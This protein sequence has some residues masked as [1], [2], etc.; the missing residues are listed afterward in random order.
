MGPC[1]PSS[2]RH[3][4]LLLCLNK[5]NI[6]DWVIRVSVSSN[7]ACDLRWSLGASFAGGTYCSHRTEHPWAIENPHT[8]KWFRQPASLRWAIENPQKQC[9]RQPTSLR[10][11]ASAV[12]HKGSEIV[13][14]LQNT[15]KNVTELATHWLLRSGDYYS[16]LT[17]ELWRQRHR[18]NYHVQPLVFWA[19]ETPA[20][21]P[22]PS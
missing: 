11:K 7:R 10:L 1:V 15:S 13:A 22:F 6:Q 3:R 18:G 17:V 21:V 16:T 8:Q 9:F 5:H 20:G 2:V 12:K 19:H 14:L 4:G